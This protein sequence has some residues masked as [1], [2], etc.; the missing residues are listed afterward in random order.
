MNDRVE[1]QTQRIY[2]N[3][4]LLAL[5]FLARIIAMRIDA[6]P[7]FRALHALAVDDGGGRT[8]FPFALL[9]ALHVERVMHAIE[10]AVLTPQIKIVEKR[11]PWRQ[12][13]RDRSPL[14]SRAQH[15]HDPVHH[16]A[17]VDVALVSTA[18][19]RWDQRFTCPHSSSVRSLGYRNLLRSYRRRFFVVHIR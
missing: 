17:H 12:I 2:E 1:Q 13:F 3:V 8:G 4:A 5:D 16:L 9:A 6:G 14:A 7:L 19:G 15:V 18:L 10:R 11:A